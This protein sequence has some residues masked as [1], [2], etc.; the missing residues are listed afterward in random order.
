VDK[1]WLLSYDNGVTYDTPCTPVNDGD[2]KFNDIRNLEAGQIFFR[3]KIATELLF[4][5]EFPLWWSR[6]KGSAACNYIYIRREYFCSGIWKTFWTG[7]FTVVNADFNLARCRVSIQPETV[8][9]Y[10]CIFDGWKAKVNLLDVQNQ[11]VF[12]EYTYE[13]IQFLM[14]Y[15][16]GGETFLCPYHDQYGDI[17]IDG[18]FVNGWNIEYVYDINPPYQYIMLMREVRV[19]N[20]VDGVPVQPPG[21]WGLVSDECSVN[22]TA[23]WARNIQFPYVFGDPVMGTVVNGEPQPPND[24]CDWIYLGG[25][26]ADGQPPPPDTLMPWYICPE[27]ATPFEYDTARNLEECINYQLESTE[28]GGVVMSDFFNW[29]PPGDAP[30]WIAGYNYVTGDINQVDALFIFQKTDV[31]FPGATNPARQ[32]VMTLQE[33]L[34]ILNQMFNVFWDIDENGN[35]RIE[36]FMYWQVQIGL[37]LT[38]IESRELFLFNSL[39]QTLP[40]FERFGMAESRGAD[41]V[42]L[43]I[44]YDS[45]CANPDEVA[46]TQI[47]NVTTDMYFIFTDPDQISRSGFVIAATSV[48]GGDD[49]VITDFGALTNTPI[50]N[51]P[52]AW[53]NLH[54]DYFTWNRYMQWGT[55]NNSLTEFLSVRPN[56]EQPDVTTALCCQTLTFDPRDSITT[57]MGQDYLSGRV[58]SVEK[59]DYEEKNNLVTLTLRYNL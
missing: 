30:G 22:G 54:R 6:R 53:A 35:L 34:K 27:T 25:F 46:E 52:L 12:A 41:F 44:I 23:T 57:N 49:T 9:R 20:C 24:D 28:C 2:V 29:S 21:S 14:C 33:M 17:I 11:T 5:D 47:P 42:G 1:R 8:D 32:G 13:N 18:V 38:A 48:V 4:K 50:T 55:M 43:D 51:A 26:T 40:R 15:G 16:E 59:V 31:I 3:R 10:S 36:H 7:R 39:S 19:T 37:D 58:A 56:I 45:P